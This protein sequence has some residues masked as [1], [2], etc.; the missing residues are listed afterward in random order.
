MGNKLHYLYLG[1]KIE[2][3][4]RNMTILVIFLKLRVFLWG[5][6]SCFLPHISK[7][8]IYP[9][10]LGGESGQIIDQWNLS[11]LFLVYASSSCGAVLTFR[12]YGGEVRTQKNNNTADAM[13]TVHIISSRIILPL[14]HTHRRQWQTDTLTQT[15]TETKTHTQKEQGTRTVVFWCL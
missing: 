3:W 9:P 8:L 11:Y 7:K 10:P 6:S 2:K 14:G 15:E 4:G 5:V 12:P 1:K 13:N